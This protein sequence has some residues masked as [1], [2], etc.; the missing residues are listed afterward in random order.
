MTR[1]RHSFRRGISQGHRTAERVVPAPAGKGA[2]AFVHLSFQEYFAAFA[3]KREVTRL[4]WAKGNASRLG[5]D[6][7]TLADWA[8][9]SLWRE[10]FAFLFELLASE[11]D[12]DWHADLLDC[13]FGE[14]FSSWRVRIPKEVSLN[15]GHLLARLKSIPALGSRPRREWRQSSL[16]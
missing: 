15:L 1:S 10:S 2:Y 11:E 12:D 7:A 4:Q 16:V 9:Q 13:V 14:N 8:G 6:R 5:F 3:L